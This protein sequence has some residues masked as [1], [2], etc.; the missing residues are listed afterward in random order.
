MFVVGGKVQRQ[1]HGASPILNQSWTTTATSNSEWIS[2]PSM[3]NFITDGWLEAETQ[4]T[5]SAVVRGAC[6]FCKVSLT[7]ARRN[8]RVTLGETKPTALI[9]AGCDPVKRNVCSR[10]H[11]PAA[12]GHNCDTVTKERRAPLQITRLRRLLKLPDGRLRKAGMAARRSASC[13]QVWALQRPQRPPPEIP[14]QQ[15]CHRSDLACPSRSPLT[16]I[17]RLRNPTGSASRT[18]L[19]TRRYSRVVTS[20]GASSVLLSTSA[21]GESAG[22]SKHSGRIRCR[23]RQNASKILSWLSSEI[24]CEVQQSLEGLQ[25]ID[26]SARI[27]VVSPFAVAVS[28]DP[29]S[30]LRFEPCARPVAP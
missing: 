20:T 26:H 11:L 19:Q 21:K 10:V 17:K 30:T 3:E 14:R 15:L 9:P 28:P 25:R 23:P 13:V 16:L 22:S 4:R 27:G 8:S 29:T 18:A 5:F 2:A 1:A 24:V 6:H 12:R 7:C